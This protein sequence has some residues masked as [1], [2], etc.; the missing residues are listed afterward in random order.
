MAAENSDEAEEDI[1]GKDARVTLTRARRPAIR[2]ERY[3][4]GVD[5]DGQRRACTDMRTYSDHLRESLYSVR[6]R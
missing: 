2:M 1:D 3:M 5:L 4:V 6:R